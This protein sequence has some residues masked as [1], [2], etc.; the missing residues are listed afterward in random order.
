[1][2]GRQGMNT[3]SLA[4]RSYAGEGLGT[5]LH[6][7]VRAAICPFAQFLGEFPKEGKILDVGCGHG[8][9]ANLLAREGGGAGRAITGIDH[10]A[11]KIAVAKRHAEGAITFSAGPVG[12]FPA[13]AFDAVS[14]VDVLYAVDIGQW[15]ALLAACSRALK[16]GGVMIV[17][18]VVDTPRWKYAAIMAEE[19][20]AVK[21]LRI[22][23]GDRPHIESAATYRAALERNGFAV[24][25]ERAL[26][27]WSWI[28]HYL[29][30]AK[31]M[32]GTGVGAA[33]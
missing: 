1:M 9:L 7:A 29:F 20:L 19:W 3:V 27:H 21:M 31:K 11:E 18:E 14:I 33:V 23:K 6:V 2:V 30:V 15:D 4:W 24:I 5:R 12:S 28:S 8:L 10:A 25:R 16:P 26:R 32:P 17:K 13:G 22:T